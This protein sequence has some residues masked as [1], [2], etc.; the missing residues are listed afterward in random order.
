MNLAEQLN[1]RFQKEGFPFE[2]EQNPECAVV[3]LPNGKTS[4]VLINNIHEVD[5][6]FNLMRVI[7]EMKPDLL[8]TC[9]HF[10]DD[11]FIIEGQNEAETPYNI[12]VYVGDE[13]KVTI[14][15]LTTV[16]D[17][18]ELTKDET[19]YIARATSKRFKRVILDDID[20]PSHIESVMTEAQSHFNIQKDEI[21]HIHNEMNNPERG[22]FQD[23]NRSQSE[24]KRTK[25]QQAVEPNSLN[26]WV[27]EQ[28]LPLRYVENNVTPSGYDDPIVKIELLTTKGEKLNEYDTSQYRFDSQLV[29]DLNFLNQLYGE[30]PNYVESAISVGD[31]TIETQ[32][33]VN[34]FAKLEHAGEGEIQL[35]VYNQKS[36]F[37]KKDEG[38]DYQSVT[39]TVNTIVTTHT[40]LQ[41]LNTDMAS[42]I[43]KSDD[44]T[45]NLTN[46][47]HQIA[48]KLLDNE[49]SVE[50][51]QIDINT[52]QM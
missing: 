19:L 40:N 35:Y 18:L 32:L 49:L 20:A 14:N 46:R 51:L 34:Q 15:N 44:F 50:D 3:K 23:L 29:S 36:G 8:N 47:Y 31:D 45:D 33:N 21:N 30:N 12:K 25:Y 7:H 38:Y 1:Q 6:T 42:T 37:D 28:G 39:T 4:D 24:S 43:A 22:N 2:A 27:R 17:R 5:Q 26:E 52:L 48:D 16:Y 9:T 41:S 11:G 10:D 13:N